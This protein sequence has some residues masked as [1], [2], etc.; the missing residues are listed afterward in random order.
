MSLFLFNLLFSFCI[1]SALVSG[2]ALCGSDAPRKTEMFMFY[3][4]PKLY[5][6]ITLSPSFV[7]LV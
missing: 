6:I 3:N 4:T 1:F 2:V 5:L 7:V